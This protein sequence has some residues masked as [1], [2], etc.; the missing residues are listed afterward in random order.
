MLEKDFIKTSGKFDSTNGLNQISYYCISPKEK[1][2]AVLQFCHGMAEHSKRY[3][4]FGE[5]LALNGIAFCICDH[6][7]HGDSINNEDDLGYFAKKEGW[8]YLVD[9]AA[10]FTKILKEQFK[11]IP[12]FIAGHSMGSFVA[13]SYISIYSELADGAIIMG[14]GN[15]TPI[16]ASGKY[17]AALV[18]KVKGERYRSKL[19][20]NL[21]FGSYTKRIKDAKTKFDWL[22]RDEKNVDK[23]ISDLKCGFIFTASGFK[24]VSSMMNFVSSKKW[25]GSVKKDLPVLLVAGES[26]PVGEYGKGV[27]KV[28]GMLKASGLKN[29]SIKLYPNCRHELLNE[30]NHQ[31]IYKDIKNWILKNSNIYSKVTS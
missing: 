30:I 14:T 18:G 20:D 2:V 23:Y 10:K 1:P 4:S 13:R 9:D 5:F 11:D 12:Y 29:A 26:D 31:E 27:K 16:I 19:L 7:G 21:S 6:I 25:A 28:Y 8:R 3:I 24:D 15:A 17:I 22:S